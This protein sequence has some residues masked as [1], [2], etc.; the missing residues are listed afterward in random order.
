MEH[1]GL[2][3]LEP[4]INTTCCSMLP[5]RRPP[6]VWRWL[7]AQGTP[8]VQPHPAGR[9][10]TRWSVILRTHSHTNIYESKNK[11]VADLCLELSTEPWWPTKQPLGAWRKPVNE[12]HEGN[13]CQHVSGRSASLGNV[14]AH[15]MNRCA[16][17]RYLDRS[18]KIS[19]HMRG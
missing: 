19:L 2:C 6:C 5:C 10:L 7:V 1:Y 8:G 14:P 15:F 17:H 18:A 4:M 16:Q 12:S 9:T 11:S 3:S 13:R